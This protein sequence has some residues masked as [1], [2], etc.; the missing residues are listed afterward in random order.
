MTP[1]FIFQISNTIALIGWLL[2]L[3]L[4]PFWPDTDK[5]ILGFIIILFALV[6]TWIMI[7]HF[8][9]QDVQKFSSLDGI[10]SLFTNK[11][12]VTAGWV[13]YLAFDLLA[14][15]WIKKNSEKFGIHHLLVVPCLLFTF[16]FG[17]VGLLLYFVIRLLKTGQYFAN[18]F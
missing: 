9:P 1:D 14:G 8:D 7:E 10:M 17:P 13:H 6:Y 3:L 11:A 4:S 12:S 5:L 16:M 2:L 15:M 18:N